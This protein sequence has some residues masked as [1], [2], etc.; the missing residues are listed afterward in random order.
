MHSFSLSTVPV[1]VLVMYRYAVGPV[2]YMAVP[3]PVPRAVG[4]A[5]QGQANFVNEPSW[6]LLQSYYAPRPC[7]VLAGLSLYDI[8]AR[9]RPDSE[10]LS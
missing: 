7:I 8:V 6:L 3:V 9:L 10:Q 5:V 4:P 1:Y 2:P